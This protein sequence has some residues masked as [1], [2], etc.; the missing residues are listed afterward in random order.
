[1]MKYL[2]ALLVF[3]LALVLAG[4]IQQNSQSVILKYF[5]Y[6]STPLPLS[7]F[8]IVAFGLGYILAILVGF[9]GTIR[10]RYRLMQAEREVKR[11]KGGSTRRR[12]NK[13]SGRSGKSDK[14]EKQG[15]SD[16]DNNDTGENEGDTPDPEKE[17]PGYDT[18]KFPS[19]ED[20]Q[21]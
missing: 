15:K 2:R 19:D 8:M 10:S 17:E 4:F 6:D 3:L 7:L 1:M 20:D 21:E 9:S 12:K 5:G 16:A 13:K 11:L 14:S 18:Q